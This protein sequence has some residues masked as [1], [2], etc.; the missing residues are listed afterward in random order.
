MA[1]CQYDS[2]NGFANLC[3]K[4]QN[5]SAAALYVTQ[6]E[7]FYGLDQYETLMF[8]SSFQKMDNCFR[9]CQISHLPESD[10]FN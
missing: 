8:K 1:V 5:D 7:H 4:E 10:C 2:W 9:K 6:F 3:G